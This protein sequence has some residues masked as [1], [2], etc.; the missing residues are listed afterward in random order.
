MRP[1]GKAC[2]RGIA[3]LRQGD[4]TRSDGMQRRSDVRVF[5]RVSTSKGRPSKPSWLRILSLWR[6][7]SQC[8]AASSAAR[9]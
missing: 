5:M 4:T 2:R 8:M 3:G 9:S 1:A 6:G 7:E